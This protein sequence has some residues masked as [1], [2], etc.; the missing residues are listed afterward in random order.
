MYAKDGLE[1]VAC[2]VVLFVLP[3]EKEGVYENFT[4][5]AIVSPL[6]AER[7]VLVNVAHE[8][9]ETPPKKP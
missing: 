1:I 6:A 9:P 4:P 2:D 8:L 5:V 3:H 7:I